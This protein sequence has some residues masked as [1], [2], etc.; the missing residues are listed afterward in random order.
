MSKLKV[1]Q[2]A[3]ELNISSKGFLYTLEELG[4]L[5]RDRMSTLAD[6]EVTRIKEAFATV[7]AEERQKKVS[8]RRR[9]NLVA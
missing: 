3:K 8:I 6:D 9:P 1:F 5:V 7:P 2:L 4:I